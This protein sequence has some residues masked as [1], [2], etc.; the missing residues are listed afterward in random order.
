V[1]VSDLDKAP[2]NLRTLELT[3]REV[4][5]LLKYGYPFPDAEAPLRNSRAVKGYHH[6]QID[7]YWIEMMI[8]DL[9]RSA[10]EIRSRVLLEELDAVCC[11][12][13]SALDDRPKLHIVDFE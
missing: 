7:A 1:T 4:Y 8:G 5:L 2:R 11:A 6:V 12:L 13:E 10:K 3:S 9:V